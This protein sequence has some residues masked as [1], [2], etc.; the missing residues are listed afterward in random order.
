MDHGVAIKSRSIF[1]HRPTGSHLSLRHKNPIQK[2]GCGTTLTR[3]RLVRL[4]KSL[5]REAIQRLRAGANLR[6]VYTIQIDHERRRM[7]LSPHHDHDALEVKRG[8]D[9]QAKLLPQ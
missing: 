5:S 8:V 9:R 7:H 6:L 1:A 2:E 3:A 4:M